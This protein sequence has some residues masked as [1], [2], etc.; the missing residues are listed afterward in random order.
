MTPVEV[1]LC[2]QATTSASGSEVGG[3]ASPGSACATIGSSRKGAAFVTA[4]NLL[5]NSPYERCSARRRTRPQA[6]ASQNAVVPP[7]PSATS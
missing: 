6:A 1:S 7:L 5:E 3:G 2:A 4:A